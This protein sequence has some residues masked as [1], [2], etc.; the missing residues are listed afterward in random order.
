MG[1]KISGELIGT[2]NGLRIYA[3]MSKS[4]KGGKDRL[5]LHVRQDNPKKWRIA[6]ALSYTN[7]IDVRFEGEHGAA[8]PE[9]DESAGES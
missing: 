6:A 3:R 7:S 5:W 2:F 8:K 4:K 1:A 9:A